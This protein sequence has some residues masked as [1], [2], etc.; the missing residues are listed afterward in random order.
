MKIKSLTT[1]FKTP[2]Q[3]AHTVAEQPEESQVTVKSSSQEAQVSPQPRSWK[4]SRTQQASL[5]KASAVKTKRTAASR[6]W[7]RRA[8][9]RPQ[10][11]AQLKRRYWGPWSRKPCG[12]VPCSPTRCGFLHAVSGKGVRTETST[13]Q[14]NGPR[15]KSRTGSMSVGATALPSL[16]QPSPAVA[17]LPAC[18]FVPCSA[19]PRPELCNCDR[20][21]LLKLDEPAAVSKRKFPCPQNCREPEPQTL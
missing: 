4:C 13:C 6:T 7:T 14:G 8:A 16:P 17:R 2:K 11:S 3:R 12:R 20:A 5:S 9:T 18:S 19:C 21:V 10:A 1:F 15:K